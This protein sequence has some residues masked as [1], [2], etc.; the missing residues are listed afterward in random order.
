MEKKTRNALFVIVIWLL[1]VGKLEINETWACWAPERRFVEIDEVKQSNQRE[2]S[3]LWTWH[4][5]PFNDL[6][7]ENFVHQWLRVSSQG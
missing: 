3:C 6:T 4:H 7:W 1:S 5:V 2:K